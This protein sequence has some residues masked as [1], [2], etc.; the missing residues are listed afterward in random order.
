MAVAAQPFSLSAVM[1]SGVSALF[2]LFVPLCL[3][4]LAVPGCAGRA[5]KG[6]PSLPARIQAGLAQFQRAAGPE[7]KKNA[8]KYPLWL[9]LPFTFSAEA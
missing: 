5:G 8:L 4:G 6:H 7:H 9:Y 2:E 3:C 1:D